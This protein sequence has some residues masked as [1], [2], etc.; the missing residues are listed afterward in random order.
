MSLSIGIIG[1]PNV[2]K[3]TVFN[4][5]TGA[6]NAEVANYPFCTIQPNRAIVPLKDPRLDKLRTLT[7]VKEI[8]YATVEFLD[9]AGL[10][11][12]ASEGEG[13]GNQFLSHVRNTDALIHVVR[14]FDDPNVIHV[15]G[16]LNPKDDIEV[17]HV[18]LAL[19]DM[20]QLERKITKLVSDIKGDRSLLPLLE[21]AKDLKEHLAA[22]NM[23]RSY[24][25]Q[26]TESFKDL[27]V[28]VLL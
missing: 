2:G 1:L 17:I 9:I 27:K 28:K 13:L 20:A 22:G 8:I 6:Q 14:G 19:S 12:G 7:G 16:V 18:E 5:L 23:V 11:K 26:N 4:A 3:S 24:P 10:V 25:N 15:H 21:L